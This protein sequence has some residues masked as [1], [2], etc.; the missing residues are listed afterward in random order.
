MRK[1]NLLAHCLKSIFHKIGMLSRA[2]LVLVFALATSPEVFAV[3]NDEPL[4]CMSP[5]A[6]DHLLKGF[7]LQKDSN[8]DEALVEYKSCLAI[9]PKC[10]SCLYEMGWSFWKKGLWREVIG[11]WQ[12]VLKIDP[13]HVKATQFLETAKQNLETVEKK[14]KVQ[15]FRLQTPI[16]SESVPVDAPVKMIFVSRWQAYNPNSDGNLDHFDTDIDS[17]KSVNF[18]PDGKQVYVNSLEGAK[19]VVIDSEG[20]K[21]VAVIKHRFTKEDA[22]LFSPTPPFDY[23]FAK[24]N[25]TPNVFTGKPVESVLT[26]SGKF[27]WVPYYRRSYDTRSVEPSAM[28]LIRTATNQIIKVFHTGPIAKYVQVSP[29]QKW[30]AVSHW[31]DNTVGL[32]D[33]SGDN[34]LRFKEQQL[35]VVEARLSLKNLKT[36]RD[37]DCGFC[38]RGLAYSSD[39]RYLFVSRMR[40]GGIAIFDLQ[41]KFKYLGTVFGINPGPR[42]LLLSPDGLM[43]YSSCNASGTVAKIPVAKLLESLTKMKEQKLVIKPADLEIKKA[44]IGLGVR[45]IKTS[46]DGRF[47]FAAANQASEVVAIDTEQMKVVSRIAVD[48]FP[49]GLSL[50]PDGHSLWVTS[51]GRAHKGGNS[52]GV[53]QVQY[54][55]DG[56]IKLSTDPRPKI[57]D[58][59]NQEDAQ[60]ETT[61]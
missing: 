9:E 21:K 32:F 46:P 48:S 59:L 40:R 33:I 11:T 41:D 53:F 22:S 52:V 37:E 8:T 3:E 6:K 51:Q 20:F 54:K 15:V 14:N 45:S 39:S 36:D 58:K 23:K 24:D 44:F 13:E 42:D 56:T 18:S 19:T 38:V 50:S 27:L 12:E 26:H 7:S 29:N 30:L 28:A 47:V 49:V 43:L 31:G 2:V 34:P 57:I 60:L 61:E 17:P 5:V 1:N 16:L 55:S 4:T 10:V 25:K 35:L